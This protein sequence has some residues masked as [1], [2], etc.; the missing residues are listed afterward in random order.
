MRSKFA[1]HVYFLYLCRPNPQER[2]YVW[3]TASLLDRTYCFW[4]SDVKVDPRSNPCRECCASK[5]VFKK[6]R[7]FVVRLFRAQNLTFSKP[8]AKVRKNN[9]S[10]KF[11]THFLKDR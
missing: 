1:H 2:S 5:L 3:P 11:F 4:L 9:D 7:R 10:C 6:N 8:S